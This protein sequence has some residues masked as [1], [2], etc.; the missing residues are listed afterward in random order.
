MA[1]QTEP[2]T[3]ARPESQLTA[4]PGRVRAGIAGVLA[5]AAAVAAGELVAGV[6]AGA[7]SLVI[8][9][10]DQVIDLVPSAVKDFAVAVFGTA[11][12][13]ALLVGI[14]I[15]LTIFAAAVGIAAA[16]RFA[17]GAGGVALFG[18]IGLAAGLGQTYGAAAGVAALPALAAT[19][20]GVAALR[21]LVAPPRRSQTGAGRPQQRERDVDRRGFIRAAGAVAVLAASVG[22]AGRYLQTRTSA[23]VS[24]AGVI[25]RRADR[26][27]PPIPAGVSADVAGMTPFVTPNAEFY[28]IDTAL[29][30]PN[31]AVEGYRLRVTGMVD[32]PLTL[33]FS[34][35]EAME[36]TEADITLTCVSNE[37]GGGLLGNARWL[38]AR[39]GDVLER[40][41]VQPGATQIVGRS[42]DGYTCGFPVQ[43][44]FD[45]RD[46]L[47]AI[48]MNGQPLPLEHG[49]PVRLVTPGLYGY[50][51]ATKWLAEIELTTYEAFDHYWA[52]RGWARQ[53]PIKTQSRIDVPRGFAR[54]APG[55]VAVAGVAWAQTRGIARVEVQID[56]GPWARAR[57]AEELNDVTWRQ[58]VYEWD[59]TPGNHQL[60]VRATDSTGHTQPEERVAPI[61]DGATGWHSV[62]VRVQAA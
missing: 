59:A 4:P 50:V 17:L 2:G 26:P 46:A 10:G 39:L 28:R 51:S 3:S 24:R 35:L 9:V 58:W 38:G 19:A 31:V 15:L 56:D 55:R 8:S 52:R 22:G 6:V 14:A 60:R 30:V 7:R 5:A 49:F 47:I 33:S 42:V 25:L 62:F 61:P 37:V 53:A 13:I 12:K 57:L 27:G 44:A 16:G 20:A 48:G 45:G 32:R 18:L 29:A 36:L 43:T 11:D 1:T 41:G 21:L 34:D 40:A 23:A 54:L